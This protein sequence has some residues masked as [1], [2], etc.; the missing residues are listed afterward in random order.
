MRWACPSVCLLSTVY[1]G[2]KVEFNSR[3]RPATN[4]QHAVDFVAGIGNKSATTW[5]RHLVAVDFVADN[6]VAD[7]ADFVVYG[8]K[9]TRSTLSTFN[10]F[11]RVEFNFVASVYR[12]L[13][14]LSVA[15]IPKRDFLKKLSS[16]ELWS[17]LT[18]YRKLYMAFERTHY[19]THKIQDGGDPPSWKSTWR[20]FSEVGGQICIKLDWCR[21]AC[22]L[23]WYGRN[24]NRK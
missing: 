18:T 7:K 21:M 5:T 12:A 20:H 16:L 24:Q 17:L 1:I 3:S 22:R 15:K 6:F 9:A 10:K 2:D 19:W 14:C 4:R 23:R 8:A 13:V 11:D